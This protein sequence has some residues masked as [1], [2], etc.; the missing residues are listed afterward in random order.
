MQVRES[1]TLRVPALNRND[2]H[3]SKN[4]VDQIDRKTFGFLAGHV[5]VILDSHDLGDLTLGGRFNCVQ[6]KCTAFLQVDR[7]SRR[8]HPAVIT[9][10]LLA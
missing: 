7:L 4:A 6:P 2:P 3:P 9:L 1:A 5:L 10:F 8:C